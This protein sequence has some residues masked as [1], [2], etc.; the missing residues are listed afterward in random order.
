MRKPWVIAT[1]VAGTLDICAAFF[2]ASRAGMTPD[3]VLQFV[4]S[5]PFGDR[6][7]GNAA[8]VP[9]GLLVHYAIM[10][11]MVGTYLAIAPRMPVLLRH[12]VPAGLAYGLLLWV[13]MYCIVRPLRWEQ[14]P[15]PTDPQAIAG[16]WFCHLV[17]VGLPIALVAA[18][19][20][21]PADAAAR[22]PRAA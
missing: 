7:L 6:A 12:P 22:L 17:L 15:P 5:G 8:F 21:R 9:V 4:A 20:L 13:V 18:R 16:Q 2:L 14:L 3:F 19:Y 11:A 1:L 10:A